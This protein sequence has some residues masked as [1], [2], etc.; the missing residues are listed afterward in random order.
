[1]QPLSAHLH[2]GV[3]ATNVSRNPAASCPHSM[4]YIKRGLPRI[5]PGGE[6]LAA[7][8]RKMNCATSG[9]SDST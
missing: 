4:H 3:I 9:Q 1:M 6:R 2:G 7:R 8:E 5:Q